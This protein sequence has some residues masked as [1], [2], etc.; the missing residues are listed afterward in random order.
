MET[1]TS[2]A[3]EK[4]VLGGK[5]D[6]VNKTFHFRSDFSLHREVY[7]SFACITKKLGFFSENSLKAI[8]STRGVG[9]GEVF[10]THKNIFFSSSSYAQVMISFVTFSF[11]PS[12]QK[13]LSPHDDSSLNWF[14][15]SSSSEIILLTLLVCSEVKCANVVSGLRST[16]SSSLLPFS[17]INND[18]ITLRLAR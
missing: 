5:L 18:H 7:S 16:H 13:E 17:T 2:S 12:L 6:F 8:L 1:R 9:Q 15:H 10:F 11:T 4:Q 14:K 3:G